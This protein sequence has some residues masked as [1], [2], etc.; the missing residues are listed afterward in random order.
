MHA[1]QSSKSFIE[2][3]EAEI[4][5]DLRKEIEA[6]VQSRYGVAPGSRT[7]PYEVAPS[8][9]V[10]AAGRLETWLA[11]HVGPITFARSSRTAYGS[12]AKRST[13]APESVLS[14]PAAQ[15]NAST[16][17]R[18]S[19]STAAELF[20]IEILNRQSP[21]PLASAFTEDELK[22]VWRKAA[23]KTHPDRFAGADQITQTRMTVLFRELAEAYETL[24]AL[25]ESKAA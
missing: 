15:P 11:S 13:P 7:S 2:V 22:A 20:A 8:A 5:A 12:S 24:L 19:A 23:L 18:F 3:L 17:V 1:S 6:E 10:H 9:A 21:T 16:V 14:K 4:R 25:S